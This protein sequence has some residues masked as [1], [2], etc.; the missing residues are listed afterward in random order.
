M[1]G[2]GFHPKMRLSALCAWHRDLLLKGME[3]RA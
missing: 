1:L 2:I 3:K